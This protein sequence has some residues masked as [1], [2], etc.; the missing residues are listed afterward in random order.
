MIHLEL[1]LRRSGGGFRDVEQDIDRRLRVVLHVT[2]SRSTVSRLDCSAR[3]RLTRLE[4]VE[5]SPSLP[6]RV[7]R[8]RHA[9][10]LPS[11]RRRGS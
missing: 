9:P 4:R 7:Q 1:F 6:R 5:S 8:V 2:V 11:S 10:Q 3:R